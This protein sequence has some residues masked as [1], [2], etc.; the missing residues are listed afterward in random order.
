MF[1]FVLIQQTFI[2]YD[3]FPLPPD[4]SFYADVIIAAHSKYQPL[5]S[6]LYVVDWRFALRHALQFSD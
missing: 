2:C 6:I 1:F 3:G 5:Q 4:T